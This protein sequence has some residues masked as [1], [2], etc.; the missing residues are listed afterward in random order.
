MSW[1]VGA[2]ILL[3]VALVFNLGL[4]AYAMYA[5]LGVM[6]ASRWMARS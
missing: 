1:Y 5:L 6:L 4:L 2:A 3:I